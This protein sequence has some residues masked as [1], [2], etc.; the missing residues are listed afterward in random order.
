MN[1]EGQVRKWFWRVDVSVLSLVSWRMLFLHRK[2]N[3]A[4]WFAIIITDNTFAPFDFPMTMLS[5][6]HRDSEICLYFFS[7]SDVFTKKHILFL[8]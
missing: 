2:S 4:S 7:S 6:K 5:Q 1:V 3:V 8:W